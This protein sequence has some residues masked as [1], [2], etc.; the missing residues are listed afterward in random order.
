MATFAKIVN[1]E[2]LKEG[3]DEYPAADKT[4]VGN[5]KLRDI[6]G[7][8]L[9]G[10][11]LTLTW[12]DDT[13]ASETSQ[14]TLPAG[15]GVATATELSFDVVSSATELATVTTTSIIALAVVDTAFGSYQVGDLLAYDHGDSAW[16]RLGNFNDFTLADNSIEPVKLKANTAT[17]KSAVRARIGAASQTDL[18][19]EST[20]R[21]TRDTQLTTLVAGKANTADLTA[22][23]TARTTAVTTLTNRIAAEESARTSADTTLTTNLAT[24]TTNRTNGDEVHVD[25]FDTQEE[26]NAITTTPG[27]RFALCTTAF[28]TYKKG[29]LLVFAED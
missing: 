26:L 19:A 25:E 27:T 4:K 23:T 13:G 21:T 8:S 11:A 5:L 20:A 1:L 18:S 22:E 17:E 29:E 3:I 28:S 16:E 15:G 24:E 7:L 10:R 12:V 14:V 6:T 2:F 9:S